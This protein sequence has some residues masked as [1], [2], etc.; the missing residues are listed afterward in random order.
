MAKIG[1]GHASAMARQ[2]L[3]ELRGALYPESNVAQSAEYGLYGTMTPG[4]V[5]ETRRDQTLNLE[6]E[7]PR[8]GTVVDQ[9]LPSAAEV[10]R[11]SLDADRGIE[12]R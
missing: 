2:G 3:R 4:E 5:A 9:R 12:R 11:D 7:A 10:G 8:Q 6:Q 1:T